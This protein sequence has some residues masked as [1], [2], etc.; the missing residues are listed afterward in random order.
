MVRTGYSG[1]RGKLIYEKNLMSKISCQTPFKCPNQ[2]PHGRLSRHRQ[3]FFVYIFGGLE[4]V[5]HSFAFVAHFVLLRGVWIRTQRAAVASIHA[6]HLPE[7]PCLGPYY[8]P[9]RALTRLDS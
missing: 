8:G 2:G 4:C 3:T 9:L 6:T 1:A 7:L 5:G